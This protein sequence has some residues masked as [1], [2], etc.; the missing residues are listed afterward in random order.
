M[1]MSITLQVAPENGKSLEGL[2][3]LH[4]LRK[5]TLVGWV[6]KSGESK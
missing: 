2:G 4:L 3:Y 5:S 1:A 6:P